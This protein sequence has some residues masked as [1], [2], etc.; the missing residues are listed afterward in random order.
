MSNPGHI[1]VEDELLA[2]YLSGEASPEEAMAVDNWVNESANNR[3]LFE[4]AR[5]VWQQTTTGTSWELPD[6]TKL[7]AAIRNERPPVKMVRL[8]FFRWSMAAAIL[9]LLGF[10]GAYLLQQSAQTPPSGSLVVRHAGKQLLRDT[11]PDQSIAIVHPDGIIEYAMDFRGSARSLHLTGSADFTVTADPAKPFIVSVGN[12]QV[13]VL[14]TVFHVEEN[15]AAVTVKV[16]SGAVRMYKGDSGITVRAGATGIY[17]N[18]TQRFHLAADSSVV[19]T[20]SFNF[21]N[22]TLKNIAGQLE[23]AYG[24]KVVFNNKKLEA[25]TMSSSFDNKSIE[26]IFEVISITLNVQYRIEKDTVYISGIGCH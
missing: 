8:N 24:V 1:Q 20:R 18:S 4:R 13:K 15:A 12:I 17:D 3:L 23:H 25:C 16:A 11:L 14:G 21:T 5:S 2:K 9:I 26:F 6:K 10:A 19:Q 22:A 7:L